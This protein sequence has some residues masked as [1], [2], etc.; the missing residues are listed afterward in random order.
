MKRKN[1]R[2]SPSAEASI[3]DHFRETRGNA[4]K[5]T[6][7]AKPKDVKGSSSAVTAPAAKQPKVS[8]P[9]KAAAR[10]V[11]E[12]H[13]PESLHR[14]VDYKRV[15]MDT[16]LKPEEAELYSYIAAQCDVPSAIDSDS[17]YG[18][19]SGTCHELRVVSAFVH[20]LLEDCSSRTARDMRPRIRKLVLNNNWP[21]IIE[22]VRGGS[23]EEAED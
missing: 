19:L 5:P 2:G 4:R 17:K 14:A 15:G 13:V 21:G 8:T 11:E 20:G 16:S 3:S 22:I 1:S 10:V 23:A 7:Q 6:A 18:P 9:Q 12:A